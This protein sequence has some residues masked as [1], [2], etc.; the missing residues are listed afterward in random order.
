MKR[1]KIIS[2]ILIICTMFLSSGTA[3]MAL[4][5]GDYLN[6]TV[7]FMQDMYYQSMTD[8]ESF[9]AALKGIFGNLDPYSG[10]FD[11]EE[12]K[13]LNMS[14]E[15]N[16]V[17]IG[18]SLEKCD[19]GILIIKV[20][21]DSPAE[22]AGLCEGDIILGVD[23][24]PAVGRDADIVATEI[25]GDAG[26]R[27]TLTIKRQSDIMDITIV[28]GLVVVNPVE[29]RFE[30]ETAYIHI[31]T[32]N[33]NTAEKFGEAMDAVAR[34]RT[35]KILLDLRDNPGGFV[36]Q[37]VAV[38]KR[39][40]P[41]GLITELDFKSERLTDMSYYSTLES[42]PYIIAVLVDENTASASEILAS[43]IQDAGNGI[44]VGQ[45]TYGKGVVQN[46]FSVITPEAYAKYHDQYGVGYITDIEWMVYHGV[47][48]TTDE[49]LGTI[50]LTTGNY[51]TRNGK[52]I[53]GI[54]INPDIKVEDRTNPNGIDIS[55]IDGLANNTGN[56]AL[57]AYDEGVY[58]AERIL[59]AAGYFTGAPDRLL[60]VETK[61]ALK[62][63]QTDEKLNASG[64]INS[65]TR[66]K[67][68]ELLKDLRVKNDPQYTKAL[69]FLR[70]FKK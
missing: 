46:M 1:M 50:K 28:R 48:P 9:K 49:I 25:R 21:E 11:D 34:M 36:D 10:F 6:S 43:A 65:T 61:T 20:Y 24:V 3:S 53:Q 27:V 68:N 47:F 15:G 18:A 31:D 52:E 54:G 35:T 63:F 69:D 14:L 42:S 39:I 55:L 60:D 58:Q 19:E 45:K 2:I 40:I 13:Q 32:F 41:K 16:F 62:K 56:L 44:L 64:E 5:Y 29:F 7:E 70:S 17:G 37:A 51:L 12:S 8:T 23:G 4:D 67:L 30:G 57:N 22:K 59:K 33:S 38:A 66:D 26:T